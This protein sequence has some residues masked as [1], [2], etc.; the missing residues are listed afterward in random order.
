MAVDLHLHSTSSDGTDAP[1]TVVALAA[2]EGLTAIALTDHDTLAGTASAAAAAERAGIGF[3]PG[4]ELSLE[5]PLGGMHLLVYHLGGTG[6]LQDRLLD[7]QHGRTGRN[8]VMVERLA[9]LGWPITIGDVIAESGGGVVGRPH[10]AAVLVRMGAA[11]S[12]ADAFD[13]WLARGR[14]AYVERLRLTP[15]EAI[16]LARRSGAVPVL[17]HPHTIGVSADE[18]RSAFG[19]LADLGLAGIESYYAEYPDE[20]RRHLAGLAAGLGLIATGGS[21]YH[22]AYKPGISVGTGHGDLRVPDEVVHAI[23]AQAR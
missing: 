12:I 16:G 15:A 11:D 17:A 23:A 14:P 9:A 2:A 10:I 5:W 7:L 4:V 19:E 22:G 18:Y 8:A 3:I 1:A 13:R 6:P 21:D 20:L